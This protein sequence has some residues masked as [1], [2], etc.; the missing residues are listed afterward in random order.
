M[1]CV[2]HCTQHQ[3]QVFTAMQLQFTTLFSL[4]FIEFWQVIVGDLIRTKLKPSSLQE[5]QPFWCCGRFLLSVHTLTELV[6]KWTDCYYF[7]LYYIFFKRSTEED[8][9]HSLSA[10][11]EM[12]LFAL[13]IQL[14]IVCKSLSQMSR[15]C[16]L[17]LPTLSKMMQIFSPTLKVL[18][19]QR[20][21]EWFLQQCRAIYAPLPYLKL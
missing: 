16:P 10:P 11:W 6:D 3:L 21:W 7:S 5:V 14:L 2:A 17:T 13:L 18:Y 15:M 1:S 12:D 8:L 9:V 20:N 19:I 4:L